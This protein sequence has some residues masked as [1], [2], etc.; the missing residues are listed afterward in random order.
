MNLRARVLSAALVL[1]TS[2]AFAQGAPPGPPAPPAPPSAPASPPIQV[3]FRGSLRDALKQIAE[4]GGLNLVVTG[5]LDR[6]AEVRLKGV[7]AEQALRTVARAYN[8]KMDHD[9]GIFTLRPL[10]EAEIAAKPPPAPA[11]PAVAPAPPELENIGDQAMS[12]EEIKERVKERAKR[13]R[14]SGRGDNDVVARGQNLVVGKDQ[15]VG[16]AVVYNGNLTVDGMV[17]DDAVV[18]G[19]NM[20]VT[21]HIEGDATAFGGNIELKPGASVSGDVASFGGVVNRAEGTNIEGSSESFGGAALGH[22]VSQSVNAALGEERA[23][24]EREKAEE[25]A[26][27]HQEHHARHRDDDHE[28]GGFAGFLLSFAMMFGLGFLFMIFAPARMKELEA[29]IKREPLKSGLVGLLGIPVVAVLGVVIGIT[30]IGIPVAIALWV[31]AILGIVMGVAALANAVGMRVPLLRGR[32]TQAAVLALG[33]L[34]MMLLFQIP[35]LGK[36]ALFLVVCVSAGA[37]IR[38]RFGQRARGLPEPIVPSPSAL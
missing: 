1:S 19:G 30:L 13:A 22:I 2:A 20:V 25:D 35:V 34:P 9:D 6:P 10:T 23:E 24:R 38:T 36:I 29:E 28:M 12:A 27:E 4:A 17:E 7:S 15:A 32:K 5:D 37:I 33:L 16:S 14:R 11:A 3:S 8:L 18:F 26:S 31:V 21:G